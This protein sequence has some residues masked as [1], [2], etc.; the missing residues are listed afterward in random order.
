ML[1]WDHVEDALKYHVYQDDEFIAIAEE[2]EFLVEGLEADTRYCFYVT[3][4][5]DSI[6]S[7]ESD[8]DCARTKD[9]ESINE[10]SSSINIYPNPVD[11]ELILATELRVEEIAIYDIYGRM[12]TAYGLQTT[13]FIHTIDVAD[14]EAGVYFVN[15]KTEN[16]NIVKRF[17]KN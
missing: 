6:E 11:N 1:T 10:L 2:T 3:A 13:D 7:D 12:T 5:N 8:E 14:L 4:V 16:G 15:I 9:G 17:I